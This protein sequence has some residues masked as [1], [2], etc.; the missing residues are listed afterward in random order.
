MLSLSFS[1]LAFYV[2]VLTGAFAV[3]SVAGFG[4]G[5]DSDPSGRTSQRPHLGFSEAGE[6]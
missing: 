2:L 3:R 6:G 1:G 4:A 5:R